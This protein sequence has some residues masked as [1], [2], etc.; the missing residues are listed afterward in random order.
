MAV[1]VFRPPVANQPPRIIPPPRP[2]HGASSP[3]SRPAAPLPLPLPLPQP[4][5]VVLPG[6][7]R[8]LPM[9]TRPVPMP[10]SHPTESGGQRE[11][12]VRNLG[13]GVSEQALTKYLSEAGLISVC[14]QHPLLC[15]LFVFC[16]VFVFGPTAHRTLAFAQSLHLDKDGKTAHVTFA[17][18]DGAVA[19]RRKFNRTVF[20]GSQ[21]TISIP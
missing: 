16:F 14:T 19:C 7:K 1:P 8:S 3:H 13:T 18:K 10:S 21:I 5:V 6:L 17:S 15:C 2:I 11:V 12:V 20:E 9:P 4:V